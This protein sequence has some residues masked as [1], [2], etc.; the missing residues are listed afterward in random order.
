MEKDERTLIMMGKYWELHKK[1]NLSPKGIATR[2]NLAPTTVYQHLDEIARMNGVTR[3]ELLDQPHEKPVSY[4][5]NDQPVAKI[6]SNKSLES[7]EKM[8]EY[9]DGELD[10]LR[11]IIETLKN[12]IGDIDEEEGDK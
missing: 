8:M 3:Q 4:D 11:G 1:E 5:R 9:L 12:E 2:F 6:D 7:Y 10:G